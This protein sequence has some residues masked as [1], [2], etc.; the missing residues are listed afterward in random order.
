MK[1]SIL[2]TLIATSFFCPLLLSCKMNSEPETVTIIG[3][4]LPLFAPHMRSFICETEASKVPPIDQQAEDWFRQAVT[5]ESP[6]IYV[7]DRDYKEIVR[8]TRQ[9]A[10]RRHWKAILNLASLYI[11]GYAP[12][13]GIND[14]IELINWAMKLGIPAAYDR[15]GT[16]FSNGTGT[17]PDSTKAYALWQRAAR[18]G[19]PNAMV[20]LGDKF[21]GIADRPNEGKW[22][23]IPVA[24]QMFECALAQGY[25]QAAYSLAYEYIIPAYRTSEKEDKAKAIEILHLGTKLGCADCANKLSIEFDHPF[26]ANRMLPLYVDLARSERYFVLGKALGFDPSRRLPNLDKILPLPPAP[27]PPWNG[28]GPTLVRAAMGIGMAPSS[29]FSE[30]T[31][32]AVGA[33]MISGGYA[34]R[35]TGEI[36]DGNVAPF[37][38]YWRPVEPVTLKPIETYASGLV[39][40]LYQRGQAFSQQLKRPIRDHK[41][42]PSVRW[43]YWITTRPA[44]NPVAPPSAKGNTRDLAIQYPQLSCT[45]DEPCPVTGTWQ[46]W[47]ASE[48]PLAMLINQHWRQAWVLAGQSFPNPRNDWLWPFPAPELRWFLMEGTN[49]SPFDI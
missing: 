10:E 26:D 38:G 13:K 9:A 46:P 22:S 41:A 17:V 6:E 18:M 42:S 36:V 8:L 5:L 12:G 31:P 16:Y 27:L 35:A 45:T 1:S 4:K 47:T 28:D 15:M 39:P 40:I 14:A 3:E 11:E 37:E 21:V 19:N 44:A 20:F 33:Y 48:L 29:P 23:N 30:P 32:D 7:D 49:D 34:L 25:G 2:S 24:K 43:E